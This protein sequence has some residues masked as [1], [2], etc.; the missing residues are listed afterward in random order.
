MH[1]DV[2]LTLN[3]GVYPLSVVQRA[4]Y[5]L[6]SSLTISVQQSDSIITLLV[7]PTLLAGSSEQLTPDAARELVLRN[8][9]DFALREQIQRETSGLREIIANAALR[10]AGL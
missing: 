9:N 6:A 1:W 10:G 8:L 7:T 5:A 4:V 2:T 3:S